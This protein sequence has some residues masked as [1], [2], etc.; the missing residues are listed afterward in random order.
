LAHAALSQ[1]KSACIVLLFTYQVL[2]LVYQFQGALESYYF[3]LGLVLIVAALAVMTARL[4]R[5]PGPGRA[6]QLTLLAAVIIATLVSGTYLYLNVSE[7]ELRQPFLERPDV[8]AGVTIVLC[9]LFLTYQVWGAILALVVAFAGFYFIF[10]NLFPGNF[11]YNPPEFEIIVSYLAGMGGA[12]GVLWGIPLSANTL[13]LIIVFGGLLKGT[14]ILELFNEFGRLLLNVSRGGI[15][16]SAILASSLIGMVTGQAVANVALSGSVTIPSMTQRGVS[17]DRAGAIE[18]VASLGSQL[19]PPIMGLGGFLMAVNLGVPYADVATAAILPAFLFVVI[20]FIA[21]YFVS[22]ITPSLKVQ[23]EKVDSRLIIWLL[24][25]FLVSFVALVTMLYLRYSPGYSALWAIG[26]LVGLAYLRPADYRPSR[27]DLW[28]GLEYGVVAAV[29]LGLILAGI[30]I[31]VQVLV[32]TGAGFDLGRTVML[33]AGDRVWLALIFGM[34]ISVLVGLGLPT[35]A[36]YALIAIIM[37]PSLIDLGIEPLIAHFFGFYFAIF[38][39]VTPPVAV[40]VM[41]ATRISG[42]SFYR[43]AVEAGRMSLVSILLPFAF[44]AFPS[45]LAFPAI[46][47][48]G[49]V[50]SAALLITALFWGAAVYGVL[51]RP[52]RLSER[53]LLL[54]APVLCI[55]MLAT[56]DT[57][58]ALAL[59]VAGA[60]FGAWNLVAMRQRRRLSRGSADV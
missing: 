56:A 49:V 14:R 18:V 26:L 21:G 7:I 39:A 9:V 53:L 59:V 5:E 13:F 12:R 40:G 42:G 19:I 24:P 4:E 23:R 50:V 46:G 48:N 28:I 45:L 20:L 8:Y 57:S 27:Q 1:L 2:I 29:N 32:T 10:G 55:V 60:G 36:A 17:K 38:S 52:L 35:P 51:G 44:V 11:R 41:A 6:L 31:V 37:I 58:V 47:F 15:C 3:H 34:L 16:Y 30:G 22:A 33:I 54:V 25:S 43:T